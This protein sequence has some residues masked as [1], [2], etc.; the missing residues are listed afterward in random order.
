MLLQV[1]NFNSGG[2]FTHF[3]THEATGHNPA[4]LVFADK[5]SIQDR[6]FHILSRI[7]V[8]VL[9]VGLPV[10]DGDPNPPSPTSSPKARQF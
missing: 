8:R 7:V 5:L 2:L 3:A 1:T 10:A 4:H 6:G 9:R